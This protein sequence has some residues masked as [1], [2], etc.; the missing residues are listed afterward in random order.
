MQEERH[1]DNTDVFWSLL[2][3]CTS[4]SSSSLDRQV[5]DAARLTGLRLDLT[6]LRAS[7]VLILI[8]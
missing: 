8:Q 2:Y 5:G 1:A 4:T 3:I 6:V 7:D